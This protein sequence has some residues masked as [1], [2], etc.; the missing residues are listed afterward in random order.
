MGCGYIGVPGF[1]FC[2]AYLN[3]FEL[4]KKMYKRDVSMIKVLPATPV[5]MINT[6]GE[7]LE[8]PRQ[9]IETFHY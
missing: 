2:V 5:L 4:K 1:I 8:K 6:D 3:N 9:L 7:G